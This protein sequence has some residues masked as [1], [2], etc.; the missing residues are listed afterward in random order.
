LAAEVRGQD[1]RSRGDAAGKAQQA[2]D[3][4]ASDQQYIFLI[5]YKQDTP[6][7]RAMVQTVK[8]GLA[9][10]ENQATLAFVQVSDPAEKALVAR[11]G[12]SRAPMPLTL[13]IAPNGAITGMFAQRVTAQAIDNAFVTPAMT[14]VM[15]SLQ[16]GKLVFVCAHDSAQSVVP[17]AIKDFQADPHFRER[18]A[19]VTLQLK[20]PAEIKFVNQMQIDSKTAETTM[21]L[22]APPGVMVGKFDPRTSKDDIAAA[23]AKA[24]KCCDDPNCKHHRN[25]PRTA[26]RAARRQQR[27]SR[28]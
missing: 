3:Q 10:R 21:V 2:L 16:E 25:Q 22:L 11:Y 27:R 5:F 4:A 20:D 7:A 8:A 28:R 23:L 19:T 12:V 14:R 24:G 9:K 13:A 17:A 1:A 18:V 15:K 6:T 26:P